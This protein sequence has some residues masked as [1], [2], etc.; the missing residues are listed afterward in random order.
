MLFRSGEQSPAPGDT[1]PVKL[2]TVV[3]YTGG[4][5]EIMWEADLLKEEDG[6]EGGLDMPLKQHGVLGVGSLRGGRLN[7][8][9]SHRRQRCM[10]RDHGHGDASNKLW[11]TWFGGKTWV[12]RERAAGG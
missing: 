2:L 3:C 1:L 9:A 4:R 5:R 7:Q 10:E 11:Q 12:E 6:V 8:A